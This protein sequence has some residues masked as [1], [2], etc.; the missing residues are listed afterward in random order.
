[1]QVWNF[2]NAVL[3]GKHLSFI[4]AAVLGFLLLGLTLSHGEVMELLVLLGHCS[5]DFFLPS[6]LHCFNKTKILLVLMVATSAG[7]LSHF[8]E[9]CN[10]LL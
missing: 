9:T 3:E 8:S 7:G 10:Y 4:L 1:M 2:L 6:W 5:G